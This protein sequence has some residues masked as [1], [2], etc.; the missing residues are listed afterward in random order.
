VLK[1][2]KSVCH[3]KE[4]DGFDLQMLSRRALKKGSH[5]LIYCLM[6]WVG[7]MVLGFSWLALLQA[8]GGFWVLGFLQDLES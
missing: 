4:S 3:T 7:S 6:W 2:K 5:H 8:L 1:K